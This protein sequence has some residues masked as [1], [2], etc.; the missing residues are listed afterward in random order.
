MDFARRGRRRAALALVMTGGTLA[1]G[2]AGQSALA[3]PDRVTAPRIAKPDCNKDPDSCKVVAVGQEA[4]RRATVA[5]KGRARCQAWR[6]E[7]YGKSAV[8]IKLWSYYLNVHWC[9]RRGRITEAS[10]DAYPET[11]VPLWSFNKQLAFRQRGGKRKSSYRVFAQGQFQLCITKLGCIQD[12]DPWI[13]VTARGN[14]THDYD[15]GG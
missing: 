1:L 10:A 4:S 12:R 13:N 11:H 3:A 2:I 8:G 15:T 9:Y 7:R 6:F 5:R 14:G